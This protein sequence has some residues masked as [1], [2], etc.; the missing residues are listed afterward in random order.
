MSNNNINQNS[1]SIFARLLASEDITVIHVPNAQTASFDLKTRTMHLPVWKEMPEHLYD[2]LIAHEVGHAIYTPNDKSSGWEIALKKICPENHSIGQLYLNI[3]ED[4]RIERLIQKKY[5]G[6]KKDFWFG[7]SDLLDRDLFEIK[8]K[9]VKE[10]SLIDRLNLK[11]KVGSFIDVGEFSEEE[12]PFVTRMETVQTWDEV[13]TLATDL[14]NY[15]AKKAQE[16]HEE[17]MQ[18]EMPDYDFSDEAEESKSEKESGS[19]N[20]SD[21]ADQPISDD[22]TEDSSKDTEENGITAVEGTGDVTGQSPSQNVS[23]PLPET[24]INLDENIKNTFVDSERKKAT[25]MANIIPVPNID[26][27][28]VSQDYIINNIHQYVGSLTNNYQS[29]FNERKIAVEN[30]IRDFQKSA[31]SSVDL[32]CKQF[33]MKKAADAHKRTSVRRTGLLDMN[34]LHSYKITDNIFLSKMTIKEGK[35]HG[36]IMFVDWSGSM[37]PVL[38]DTL[39]QMMVL[40]SFCRRCNIPYEI[41]AFCTRNPKIQQNPY[42]LSDDISNSIWE[43]NKNSPIPYLSLKPFCLMNLFSSSND[44]NREFEMMT[45]CMGYAL[46]YENQENSALRYKSLIVFLPQWFQLH[47]TPLDE[48]IAC[49]PELH[50]KFVAKYGRQINHIVMLT[51]GES[52]NAGYEYCSSMI[53]PKT[54]SRFSCKYKNLGLYA[55][56]PRTQGL[57]SWAKDRTQSNIVCI[58]LYSRPGHNHYV[59]NYGLDINRKI[60]LERKNTSQWN[61]ENYV[62]VPNDLHSYDS[63]FIVKAKNAVMTEEFDNIDTSNMTATKI[64]TSFIKHQKKKFMSRYMINRFVEMIAA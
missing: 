31:K 38:A 57:I 24:Q 4:A 44:K 12:T 53:D 58:Q 33:E 40:M 20:K 62:D 34:N 22:K 27:I 56:S 14:Y 28:V 30:T 13:V 41:Y 55:T 10:L 3:V 51:D 25:D 21:V 64:K 17:L 5:P 46:A 7:Y 59:F 26:N 39:R 1:K 52:D 42:M 50:S 6:S 23:V 49:I 9:N 37:G 8:D 11:F 35:N 36:L 2:M 15:M 18:F 29:M 19:S 61:R 16:E 32:L 45:Y 48:A 60:E 63:L 47:S 43:L 54:K